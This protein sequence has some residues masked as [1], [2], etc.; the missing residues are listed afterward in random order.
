[1]RQDLQ[2][3]PE[4][5]QFCIS[6]YQ[7]IRQLIKKCNANLGPFLKHNEYCCPFGNAFHVFAVLCRYIRL[8]AVLTCSVLPSDYLLRG[9][10]NKIKRN[11]L[12]CLW[13]CLVCKVLCINQHPVTM[14]ICPPHTRCGLMTI[15]NVHF[16]SPSFFFTSG[17]H[18]LML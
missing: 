18:H 11:L 13:R 9:K 17:N 12:P 2:K 7:A 15:F 8:E 5:L 10:A 3:M 1:M 6:G 14:T 16:N 4:S